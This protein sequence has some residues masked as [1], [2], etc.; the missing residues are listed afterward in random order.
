MSS[1]VS[2]KK[3]SGNQKFV[4]AQVN[5][6]DLS[7]ADS[8]PSPVS[9]DLERKTRECETARKLIEVMRQHRQEDLATI[10]ALKT[11]VS[12]LEASVEGQ[13]T[14]TAEL[15]VVRNTN[16]DLATQVTQLTTA[17]R[18]KEV[19]IES[20]VSAMDKKTRDYDMLVAK[21][22]GD[23]R[24]KTDE[25][26]NLSNQVSTLI[27]QS[28]TAAA[29]LEKERSIEKAAVKKSELLVAELTAAKQAAERRAR[30]AESKQI[31]LSDEIQSLKTTLAKEDSIEKD[32]REEIENLL[33]QQTQAIEKVS[34]A[35]T[36]ADA[37]SK[38]LAD[39]NKK[40]KTLSQHVTTLENTI[41]KKDTLIDQLRKSDSFN[42]A[43]H[44][45]HVLTLKNQYSKNAVIVA[46]VSVVV[47]QIIFLILSRTI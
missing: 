37:T 8:I 27:E 33:L 11:Q 40:M 18:V 19:E 14:A 44:K 20:V 22:S 17:L 46:I 31:Q 47:S 4:R 42:I 7:S 13:A 30:T 26:R 41:S 39:A 5:V 32:L 45:Q 9:A 3:S 36:H 21:S 24:V 2:G 28:R 38:L 23:L 6:S 35:N 43:S 16:I 12:E 15:M 1:A 29:T 34:V 25:I 10:T